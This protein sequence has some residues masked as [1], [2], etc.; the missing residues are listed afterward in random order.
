M[1][2]S[3][4]AGLVVADV[5]VRCVERKSVMVRNGSKR[6]LHL[7]VKIFN[8][9]TIS[10]RLLCCRISSDSP[11]LC[12]F[13]PFSPVVAVDERGE[14]LLEYMPRIK[15]VTNTKG[16]ANRNTTS[17]Y[18]VIAQNAATIKKLSHGSVCVHDNN[19]ANLLSGTMK[20]CE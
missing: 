11:L 7:D 14:Y 18:R 3:V 9:S 17:P 8:T 4:R 6:M 5:A 20:G 10:S 2:S 13:C 12:P 1:N 15:K 19:P 16:P